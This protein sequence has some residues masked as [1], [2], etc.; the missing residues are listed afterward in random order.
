MP[1]ATADYVIVGAGSAG[2]VLAARLSADPGRSVLLLEAGG[3][4]RR[5]EVA[6]PAAYPRLFG[7][8]YDWAFRT[9]RQPGLGGRRTAWPRG[10][11]LG[12]SSSI[13]A[14]IWTR[15]LPSDYDEWGLPGWSDRDL[16]PYV[17]RAE[18]ME[19]DEDP[20]A[21]RPH[22]SELRDPSP[23]TAGFL[24][25]CREAGLPE[26]APEGFG[27]VRVTQ[28]HG[29]RWSAAD[30][31]LKPATR[32]PNLTVLTGA[33]VLRL[34][35]EDGVATGVE[36]RLDGERQHLRA[37]REVIVSAGAVNSPALLLR[38]GVG[39][40]EQ[41]VPLSIPVL[42]DRLAVGGN[43]AD[44]LYVPV[45]ADSPQPVSPGLDDPQAAAREYLSRRTGPLSSNLAEALAFVAT[46]G[47]GPPDLE[48][49]WMIVPELGP[50]QASRHGV[51]VASVL[52]KPASRGRV[53][54]DP[55]DPAG[56]PL[57]DPGY[58]SDPEGQDLATLRRGV[59]LARRV[60]S[61]PALQSWVKQLPVPD[62]AGDDELDRLVRARATTLYHP[63][64]TCRMGA[65]PDAVVDLSLR[66]RGLRGLRVVDASVLPEI[67]RAH[68][69]APTVTVA[70]RAADLILA[71]SP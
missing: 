46:L 38:S 39:D 16:L 42:V 65:D 49:L 5:A 13:N 60:L 53:R 15:S 71:E 56:P 36:V 21:P 22:L 18:Q 55:A 48:L 62:P 66:V 57:I 51:T 70:E 68:T 30:S 50:E 25:A 45:S 52:L 44:H 41:L 34:L 2:C 31:Y 54:L 17:Q 63:T 58:L 29:R 9:I 28:N 19:D 67:P 3:P 64:G 8:S 47:A 27:P 33:E 32:R 40:P 35:I 12:G 61:R 11:T 6:M 10:R 37:A 24:A 23:S 69:H 59:R 14:Q 43:L 26:S 20:T 4:D 7:S 1:V